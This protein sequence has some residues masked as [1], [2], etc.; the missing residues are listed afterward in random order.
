GFGRCAVPAAVCAALGCAAR[1]TRQKR[2]VCNFGLPLPCVP[3]ALP[4]AAVSRECFARNAE[5]PGRLLRKGALDRMSPSAERALLP[6][7]RGKDD[8]RALAPTALICVSE[9]SEASR[10]TDCR[11]PAACLRFPQRDATRRAEA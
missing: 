1:V 5:R 2:N 11:S 7:S 3:G 10:P 6:T 4:D 9:H 8:G